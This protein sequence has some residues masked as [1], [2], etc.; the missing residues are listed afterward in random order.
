MRKLFTA[1]MGAI[2]ALIFILSSSAA[3]RGGADTNSVRPLSAEE[4][5]EMWG[6]FSRAGIFTMALQCD[7]EYAAHKKNLP[8][9]V[10]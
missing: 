1:V 6:E 10:Q 5:N 4:A 2:A 9:K 7:R 8:E 3:P